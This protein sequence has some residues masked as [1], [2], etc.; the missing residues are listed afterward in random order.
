MESFEKGIKLHNLR[1][2]LHV[3]TN[4][5][6]NPIED[7]EKSASGIYKNNA[8]NRKHGRVGERYG[9]MVN[10]GSTQNMESNDKDIADTFQKFIKKFAKD[11][12][13]IG[14]W[15]SQKNYLII[16]FNAQDDNIR[17]QTIQ[18]L[19]TNK[20]LNEHL[21]GIDSVEGKIGFHP[22]KLGKFY[23]DLKAKWDKMDTGPD[24]GATAH[25]MRKAA[26]ATL[27][28]A[29]EAGLISKE[30]F[31]K[32]RAGTYKPN[33]ENQKKGVAGQK[34][35]QAAQ[36]DQPGAGQQPKI[37]EADLVEHAKLASEQAL[38]NAI[39]TS[40]DPIVRQVAHKE[41]QRRLQ[42][43]K[44]SGKDEFP[45]RDFVTGQGGKQAADAEAKKKQQAEE[46]M[47]KYAQMKAGHKKELS[48]H[49]QKLK[50]AAKNQHAEGKE[51]SALHTK[52]FS[53]LTKKQGKNPSG[54]EY[55]KMAERHKKEFQEHL[56]KHND[57]Q[58][59]L[60]QE[61][62]QLHEKHTQ[63]SDK[64]FGIVGKKPA[65]KKTT[66]NQKSEA[67]QPDPAKLKKIVN[68]IG[69]D[70]DG[71]AK[72][73]FKGAKAY[74]GCVYIMYKTLKDIGAGTEPNEAFSE[75]CDD[76]NFHGDRPDIK[77]DRDL[78]QRVLKQ[79]A[80]VAVSYR[81]DAKAKPIEKSIIGLH[82]F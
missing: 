36:P 31:E 74:G 48:E 47:Q 29:L 41:L 49:D 27:L 73:Y 12:P 17:K 68:E 80:G 37:T 44:P 38:S 43:E 61:K 11:S 58:K 18:E 60:M 8:E 62:D 13:W 65:E 79:V 30:V 45:S 78:V 66:D 64:F 1:Q 3:E 59:K 70:M 21:A 71:A 5:V 81:D 32:A 6:D 77:A 4:I 24:N 20:I 28:K 39:K 76:E 51:L 46:H 72:K 75:A 56:N 26:E 42:E 53:D 55:R 35:G 25:L 9:N 57:I 82:Y 15:G 50:E 14:A 40:P 2:V 19:Q 54:S 63:E 16:P 69:S 34:Y 22:E 52:E 23:K 10:G 7:L 33:A 67:N